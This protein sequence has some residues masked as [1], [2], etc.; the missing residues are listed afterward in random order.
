MGGSEN[1]CGSS[2]T[3]VLSYCKTLQGPTW[4]IVLVPFIKQHMYQVVVSFLILLS[5]QTAE[6]NYT[7]F[8]EQTW[9]SEHD[10]RG[11]DNIK[12]RTKWGC[13]DG[14]TFFCLLFPLVYYWACNVDLALSH[15]RTLMGGIGLSLASRAAHWPSGGN[16]Y[17]RDIKAYLKLII[18]KGKLWEDSD[19][20]NPSRWSYLCV[21]NPSSSR[22]SNSALVKIIPPSLLLFLPIW[23]LYMFQITVTL[24]KWQKQTETAF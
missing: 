13:L 8:L 1:W 12:K 16:H 7:W 9:F 14:S 2:G 6:V 24:R 11:P 21:G 18:F 19:L 23:D 15:P 20:P 17:L 5:V 10:I 4:A 22:K 3:L